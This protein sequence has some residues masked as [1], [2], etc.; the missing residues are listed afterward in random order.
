M[1][2]FILPILLLV[3]APIACLNAS[4]NDA[5]PEAVP[6]TEQV[7]SPIGSGLALT[8]EQLTNYAVL[9]KIKKNPFQDLISEIAC[10]DT[11]CNV[12]QYGAY[13]T[14]SFGQT[15][16]LAQ[17]ERDSEIIRRRKD[18]Y[19]PLVQITRNQQERTIV[20]HK[21]PISIKADLKIEEDK[22]SCVVQ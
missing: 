21:M 9:C 6:T 22:H 4:T 20:L 2:S 10:Q 12:G 7:G 19:D 1:K 16:D 11:Q 17:F 5:R 15:A 13:M 18:Q 8:E 14:L 3:L